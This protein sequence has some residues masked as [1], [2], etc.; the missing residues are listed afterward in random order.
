MCNLKNLYNCLAFAVFSASSYHRPGWAFS[1]FFSCERNLFLFF[2]TWKM[3]MLCSWFQEL[4]LQKDN[5]TLNLKLELGANSC[6]LIKTS[7]T[8]WT[9]VIKNS[10]SI[11]HERKQKK[12]G[13]P[14]SWLLVGIVFYTQIGTSKCVSMW[15][16][17]SN[18]RHKRYCQKLRK[19]SVYF[20]NTS[21]EINKCLNSAG[22]LWVIKNMVMYPWWYNFMTVIFC[23]MYIL[24]VLF[25][26]NINQA[27]TIQYMKYATRIKYTVKTKLSG[28]LKRDCYSMPTS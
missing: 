26:L 20:S 7:H 15:S 16:S 18:S 27:K 5:R 2:L 4:E 22:K 23:L 10:K 8:I 24:I 25:L 6:T 1:F 13:M 12:K 14:C 9:A 17:G 11:V 19:E 21:S 28:R 3:T